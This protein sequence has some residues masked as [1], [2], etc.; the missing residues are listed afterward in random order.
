MQKLI[1]VMP[2]LAIWW[3]MNYLLEVSQEELT[4]DENALRHS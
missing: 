1:D 3:V 2:L 4:A